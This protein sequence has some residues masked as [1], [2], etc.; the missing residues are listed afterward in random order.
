MH[1]LLHP[2]AVA[3]AI[4]FELALVAGLDEA[5]AALAAPSPVGNWAAGRPSTPQC[6]TSGR[7]LAAGRLEAMKRNR[8][9][10]AARPARPSGAPFALGR[11][12][13]RGASTGIA[14]ATLIRAAKGGKLAR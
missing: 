7:L 3:G 6:G 12:A 13:R 5:P 10:E 8:G 14:A 11:R 4:R 2:G 1:E 9:G